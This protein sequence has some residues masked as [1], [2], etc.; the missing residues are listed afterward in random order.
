MGL[1]ANKPDPQLCDSV[2]IFESMLTPVFLFGDWK[3]N[4]IKFVI[5]KSI[6]LQVEERIFLAYLGSKFKFWE[7]VLWLHGKIES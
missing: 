6:I 3:E 2:L 7:Y 5:E 4:P 1:W